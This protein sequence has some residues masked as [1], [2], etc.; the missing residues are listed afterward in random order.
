[1]TL[2]TFVARVSVVLITQAGA[3]GLSAETPRLT[4]TGGPTVVAPRID[5]AYLSRYSPPM[6]GEYTSEAEQALQLEGRRSAGFWIALAW[7]PGGRLGLETRVDVGGDGMTGLSGPYDVRLRYHARQPPDHM[8]REYE[9]TRSTTVPS[10]E[11]SLRLVVVAANAAVRLNPEGRVH[12]T[13][14]GGLSLGTMRGRLAPVGFT[15]FRLGGHAVLFSD[16][17][18]VELVFG[19]TTRIGV[20]AGGDLDIPLSG[21]VAVVL[22]GR[23]MAFRDAQMNARVGNRIDFSDAVTTRSA[24]EIQRLLQPAPLRLR[25]R[26]AAV[27]AGLRIGL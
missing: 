12:G 26:F 2:H 25:P 14:S 22:G 4:I 17:Y 7:F 23:L 24:Q 8:L 10:A 6:E 11:T 3:A 9:F 27:S 19:P 18:G 1:M 20:N 16:Q 21:R 13:L 5:A 15:T